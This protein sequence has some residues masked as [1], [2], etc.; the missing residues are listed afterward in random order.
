MKLLFLASTGEY[1]GSSTALYNIIKTLKDRIEIIVIFPNRGKFSCEIE[2]IGIKCIYIHYKFQLYPPFKTFKNIII[3]IPRAINQVFLGIFSRVKLTKIIRDINPD[4]VHTNVGPVYVG[5]LI[6][7]KLNIPHV[8]HI[9][10]YQDLDFDMH[11]FPSKNFFIKSLKATNN[12]P[13]AITEDI[14]NYFQMGNNASI[15]YDGVFGED[16]LPEIIGNKS[17]Y[18]LFVGRLEIAKGIDDAIKAF[19]EFAKKT[20]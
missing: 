9:R 16:A 2:L 13:I 3:Y 1:G 7:K 20:T 12:F 17:K 8:W 4:I 5:Y 19:C 6:A 15:I 14:R 18:F 10:E 11:F